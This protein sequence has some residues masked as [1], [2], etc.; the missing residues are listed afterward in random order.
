[1]EK[2]QPLLLMPPTAK[3]SLSSVLRLAK[4]LPS[5]VKRKQMMTV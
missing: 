3:P 5:K 2:R 1:M 4:F